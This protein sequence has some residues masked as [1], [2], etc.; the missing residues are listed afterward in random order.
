MDYCFNPICDNVVP[1]GKLFCAACEKEIGHIACDENTFEISFPIY[2]IKKIQRRKKFKVMLKKIK[3]WLFVRNK[4]CHHACPFCEYY[5]LC[6]ADLDAE[7]S[8]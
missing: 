7:R 1:E 4:G 8:K 5:D 2:N 3:Y 6:R